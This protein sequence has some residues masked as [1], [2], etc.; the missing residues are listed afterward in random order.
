MF[1]SFFCPKKNK[2]SWE[3]IFDHYQLGDGFELQFCGARFKE[4]HLTQHPITRI[5]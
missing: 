3:N 1:P 2:N 5:I 4:Q